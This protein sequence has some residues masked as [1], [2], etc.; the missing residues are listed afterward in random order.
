[1]EALLRVRR[2]GI[3]GTDL[4]IYEGHLDARVGKG[5]VIGDETFAGGVEAR[6]GGGV[7][8]GDLVVLNP[9]VSCG[10]C[11]ACKMGASYVCYNLKVRG[12]DVDGGMREL[13]PVPV[14]RLLKVRDARAGEQA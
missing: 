14:G 7:R 10:E 6:A 3:C 2:V 1:G 11:R 5:R 13:D 12:V 8:A 9:V 4:H